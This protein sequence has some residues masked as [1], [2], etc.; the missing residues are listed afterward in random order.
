MNNK[1]NINIAQPE[2][3]PA[4][5]ILLEAL[6]I[7]EAEFKPNLENQRRG[8]LKIIESPQIG[9]ILIAK[10]DDVA[11]GMVNIL[12]TV[13]TALGERVAL[14]EDMVVAEAYRNMGY[15]NTIIEYAIA[16]AR[17]QQCTRMTLL[18]DNKNESA[19]R[20]YERYGFIRSGMLPFRL[21][22]D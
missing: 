21:S 12:F 11:V 16:E 1:L 20:F 5:C 13:S 10:L 17:R 15:G 8:L 22:L 4:L 7:Q 6:F 18:T 2:D 3:I 19:Q 14:L 9:F